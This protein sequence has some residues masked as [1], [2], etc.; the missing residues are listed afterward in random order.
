MEQDPLEMRI[1]PIAHLYLFFEMTER[2]ETK[3][4]KGECVCKKIEIKN[5]SSIKFSY[6]R[7]D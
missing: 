7:I 1:L 6:V 3:R 5:D 2:S 4:G